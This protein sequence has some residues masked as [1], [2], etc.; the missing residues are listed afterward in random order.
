MGYVAL[1]AFGIGVLTTMFLPA[2]A[3]VGISAIFS[4]AFGAV[5]LYNKI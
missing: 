1:P 3:V 4:I 5:C 2:C